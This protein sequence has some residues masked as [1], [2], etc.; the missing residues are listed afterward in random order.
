MASRLNASYTA[1]RSRL[2]EDQRMQLKGA[3]S[4]WFALRNKDCEFEAGAA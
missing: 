4:A 2:A 1:V 3:Q